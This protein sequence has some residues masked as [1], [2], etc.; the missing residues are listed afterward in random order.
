MTQTGVPQ[1]TKLKPTILFLMV[2]FVGDKM[3]FDFK[4]VSIADHNN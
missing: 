1:G 3:I 4:R 2:N